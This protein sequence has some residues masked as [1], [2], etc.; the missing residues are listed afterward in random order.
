MKHH[1]TEVLNVLRKIKKIKKVYG[2]LVYVNAFGPGRP[3]K[4]SKHLLGLCDMAEFLFTESKIS[5][6]EYRAFVHW[7]KSRPERKPVYWWVEKSP[8]RW[9]FLDRSIKELENN[10]IY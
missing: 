1:I 8:Y 7:M 3:R 6:K 4:F 2:D 5:E 10:F 9:K